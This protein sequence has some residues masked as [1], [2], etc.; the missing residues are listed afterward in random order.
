MAKVAELLSDRKINIASMQLYRM[1]RNGTAIM[2]LE[3]DQV[4]ALADLR[5]GS[6]EEEASSIAFQVYRIC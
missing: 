3:T 2:A 1:S 6:Y 4:N 5:L